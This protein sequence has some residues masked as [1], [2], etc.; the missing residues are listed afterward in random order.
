MVALSNSTI[1]RTRK[2]LNNVHKIIRVI[3][4]MRN[5]LTQKSFV[6]QPNIEMKIYAYTRNSSYAHPYDVV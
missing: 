5:M 4:I 1:A 3:I 6:S 2:N